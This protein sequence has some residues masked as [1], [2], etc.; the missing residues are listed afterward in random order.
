MSPLSFGR[1]RPS[2]L[3][4]FHL[5]LLQGLPLRVYQSDVGEEDRNS[6]KKHPDK[7]SINQIVA[8]EIT[9]TSWHLDL[10]TRTSDVVIHQLLPIYHQYIT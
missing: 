9:P 1:R 4:P 2:S 8:L 3:R 7:K 6:E 5:R 10:F